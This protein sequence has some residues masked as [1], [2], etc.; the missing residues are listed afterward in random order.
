MQSYFF[1][2]LLLP[3]V[4]L[5]SCDVARTSG[6]G[7]I[8]AYTPQCDLNNPALYAPLQCHGSIGYCW[9]VNVNTGVKEGIARPSASMIHLN[10]NI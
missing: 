9:C 7:L 8:G 10:C 2:F 1:V 5:S 3:Y 4:S 6:A